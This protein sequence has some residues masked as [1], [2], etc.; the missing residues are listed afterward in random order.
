MLDISNLSKGEL[1]EL[2]DRVSDL[3]NSYLES[4]DQ[5]LYELIEFFNQSCRNEKIDMFMDSFETIDS[6]SLQINDSVEIIYDYGP[7][8][9]DTI[10]SLVKR[11]ISYIRVYKTLEDLEVDELEFEQ[12]NLRFTTISF[13]YK[14]VNFLL[15]EDRFLKTM[16]LTGSL[17]QSDKDTEKTFRY[18]DIYMNVSTDDQS[19]VKVKLVDSQ[20]VSFESLRNDIDSM[21]D[22]ILDVALDLSGF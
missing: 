14:N 1:L 13:L 22:K 3:L 10:K 16:M 15:H 21:T 4:A 8:D 12:F 6:V 2:R 19:K 18:G 5:D 7:E 9:E 11:H 17:L 20:S